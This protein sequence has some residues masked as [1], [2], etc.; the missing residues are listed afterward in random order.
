MMSLAT[1]V[2]VCSKLPLCSPQILVFN[3]RNEFSPQP[4]IEC[5]LDK[6]EDGGV[7][8]DWPIFW[9]TVRLQ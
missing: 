6:K 5:E 4:K 7:V 3:L 9:Q 8:S 2:R 1:A